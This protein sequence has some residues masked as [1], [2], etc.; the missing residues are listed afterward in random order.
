[1][2]VGER[3]MVYIP[4]QLGYGSSGSSD[5]NIPGYSALAFDIQL[6]GVVEDD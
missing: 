6:D 4:W 3:W 1:M 2:Y 5:G